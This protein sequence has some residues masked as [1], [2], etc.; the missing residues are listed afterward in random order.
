MRLVKRV[1]KVKGKLYIVKQEENYFVWCDR[2]ASLGVDSTPRQITITR[3]IF[4]TNQSPV[5]LDVSG[6][7]LLP[8]PLSPLVCVHVC[9]ACPPYFSLLLQRRRFAGSIKPLWRTRKSN[10]PL[11]YSPATRFAKE[12]DTI[13]LPPPPT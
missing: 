5:G 13:H 4:T 10:S 8:P 2:D 3:E 6:I 12:L 7:P 11:L 9:V 1:L